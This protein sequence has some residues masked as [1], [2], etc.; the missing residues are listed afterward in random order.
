MRVFCC[1][2]VLTSHFELSSP[3]A[4]SQKT[5]NE[6]LFLCC[7]ALRPLTR[8]KED[9]RKENESPFSGLICPYRRNFLLGKKKISSRREEIQFL[10]ARRK[11]S[12]PEEDF[13][14]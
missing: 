9:F 11:F 5:K 12:T 4:I 2:F 6:K 1:F 10:L 3:R 13:D 8:S 14:E 7:R